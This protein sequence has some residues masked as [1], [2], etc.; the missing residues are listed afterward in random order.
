[1]RIVLKNKK[2]TFVDFTYYVCCSRC[3]GLSILIK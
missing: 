2:K 3:S 1:M